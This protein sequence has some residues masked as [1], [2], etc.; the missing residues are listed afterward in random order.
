MLSDQERSTLENAADKLEEDGHAGAQI[1]RDLTEGE[2]LAQPPVMRSMPHQH[3]H[4][5]SETRIHG[6]RLQTPKRAILDS[7]S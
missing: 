1:L 2:R 4:T 3:Q 5:T 7:V 6:Q